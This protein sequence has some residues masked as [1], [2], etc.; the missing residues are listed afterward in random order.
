MK[1]IAWGRGSLRILLL[2]LACMSTFRAAQAQQLFTLR[3]VASGLE[4]PVEMA[5]AGDGS[6]RLFIV[7][8]PGRIRILKNGVLLET[9]FIDL[10]SV[11][12]SGGERGLLGLAFHP[13]YAANRRFYVFYT[14]QPDGAVQVSEY[15]AS[16]ADPDLADP[17]SARPI[18]TVPHPGHATNGGRIA[19][20]PEGYLYIGIG[21]SADSNNPDGNGQNKDVLVGKILRIDVNTPSGYAVP[22]T[23]PFVGRDGADEVWAYGLRNPW[24]FSF[25]LAGLLIAD[26]GEG[27]WEEINKEY[28][29]FPGGAN[30]GSPI[31]EGEHCLHPWVGCDTSGK[32]TPYLSHSHGEDLEGW[33][34]IIGGY[35]YRGRKS[36][37][38]HGFYLY[39][40][41][42]RAEIRVTRPHD[43]WGFS[44]TIGVGPGGGHTTFGEDEDGELYIAS[45]D[46]TVHAIDGVGPVVP[47]RVANDFDGDGMA[48]LLWRNATSGQNYLFPMDGTAIQA[49]EGY[50]RS[51][52][53]PS[54]HIAGVGDFDGDGKAD[55][56]W[57]NSVT[58]RNYLYFMDGTSI[59]LENY[60]HTVA[61]VNW[62]VAGI[63]DFDGSGTADLL[64]RNA[65]TGENYIHL[66]Y[67]NGIVGQSYVRTV[68]DPSWQVAGVADFDGDRRA[69]ILWRNSA[70]GQNY[71]FPMIQTDINKV[72]VKPTE[73]YVRTV[74]DQSWKVAAVG[75]FDGDGK[76]DI[77]WR[78]SSSGET[79]LF[80]MTGNAIKPGE[81]YVRRVPD[82]NWTVQAAADFD[83]D[84]KQDLFWRN[85]SSGQN[86]IFFMD[87]TAIKPS[88]G[89]VR[90][91]PQ[92]DWNVVGP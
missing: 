51:V 71:L 16:A 58:G 49:G 35:V 79:Y 38:L 6:K 88:E 33:H 59:L 72:D 48:D 12:L 64:W 21:D 7:E 2:V 22:P 8:Q 17:G 40:D 55:M 81:G 41:V 89:Y 76:A 86:Y 3:T 18:I 68:A 73:G 15:Q 14:R 83:G 44:Q 77:F 42:W 85:A 4:L 57:R 90:T 13:Q 5:N 24:K 78:N 27:S 70:T 43:L 26:V 62:Q 75:D 63:G 45:L 29:T 80:P 9:P 66:M 39:A 20:G 46:G 23:N 47:P 34:A 32:R 30:F 65:A 74:A 10:G 60:W 84:G 92:T 36:S 53:D 28:S 31:M 1:K 91:V 25:D 11:V 61:D 50:L 54:W 19:F 69:D 37:R 67:G 87:G 56:F 82:L 52:S